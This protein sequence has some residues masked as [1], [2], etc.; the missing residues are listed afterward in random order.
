MV[1]WTSAL[2]WLA[3]GVN[4]L[5]GG[6]PEFGVRRL[7]SRG[8]TAAGLKSHSIDAIL[9]EE[10]QWARG[11]RRGDP[12]FGCYLGHR[13]LNVARCSPVTVHVGSHFGSHLDTI[14]G[15]LF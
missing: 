12:P 7:A 13:S 8:S 4:T 2:Y 5:P 3:E 15:K 1:A 6:V 9:V 10:F 14:F 11:R